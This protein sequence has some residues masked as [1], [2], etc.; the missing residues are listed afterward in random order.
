[1]DSD[2]KQDGWRYRLGLFVFFGALP[3]PV[4]APFVIPL[5]GLP[6]TETAALIGGVLVVAEL[7]LVGSVPLLGKEGFQAL[8]ATVFGWLKLPDGPVSRRRHRFGVTLLIGSLL[9]DVAL[10]LGIVLSAF[11]VTNAEDPTLDFLGLDFDQQLGPGESGLDAS[12]RRGM[13]LDDPVI[14]NLVHLCEVFHVAQ[15]DRR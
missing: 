2:T 6:T 1:M 9:L 10:N 12:A 5:L 14:P 13:P 4:I 3:V 15:I 11:V 8:K 7:L